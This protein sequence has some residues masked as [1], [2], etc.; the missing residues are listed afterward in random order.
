MVSEA[1]PLLAYSL[2]VRLTCQCLQLVGQQ[3]VMVQQDQEQLMEQCAWGL[4]CPA[5]EQGLAACLSFEGHLRWQAVLWSHLRLLRHLSGT[6]A[7]LH[8]SVKQ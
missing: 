3:Q 6:K 5:A 8:S 2:A 1:V 4:C 7:R